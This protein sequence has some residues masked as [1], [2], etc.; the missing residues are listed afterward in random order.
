MT[1]RKKLQSFVF[2]SILVLTACSGPS[3]SELA[4]DPA[5]TLSEEDIEILEEA[6]FEDEELDD[7]EGIRLED[8]CLIGVWTI[9]HDSFANYLS[10]SMNMSD[11]ITFNIKEIRGDLILSFDGE[12]M[13]FQT[14]SDPIQVTIEIVAGDFLLGESTVAVN[15]FGQAEYYVYPIEMDPEFVSDILVSRSADYEMSADG[16][17]TLDMNEALSATASVSLTPG[18]FAVTAI[19]NDPVYNYIYSDSS[20][21]GQNVGYANYECADSKLTLLSFS[22]TRYDQLIF[23]RR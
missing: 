6:E 3:E 12:E 5:V 20:N 2:A 22:A 16:G 17:F 1:Y 19:N 15:A 7:S 13:G 23:L 21:E 9:D 18:S 4:A 11:E 8:E 14:Q 10:A